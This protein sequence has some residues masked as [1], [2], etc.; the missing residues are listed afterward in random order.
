MS[1]SD[2]KSDISGKLKDI[3]A[4]IE[5]REGRKVE[6]IK[7]KILKESLSKAKPSG[8]CA[9]TYV[10]VNLEDL[11]LYMY[12]CIIHVCVFLSHSSLHLHAHCIKST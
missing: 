2:K 1:S 7:R 10:Q 6:L 12:V 5:A 4:E 11:Y 9:S 3:V 8:T